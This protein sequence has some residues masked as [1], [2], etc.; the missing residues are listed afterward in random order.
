MKEQEKKK[1]L[2]KNF[3]WPDAEGAAFQRA[4]DATG[5]ETGELESGTPSPMGNASTARNTSMAGESEY[6]ILYPEVRRHD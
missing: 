2:K 6:G 5:E 1:T 3:P 4:G